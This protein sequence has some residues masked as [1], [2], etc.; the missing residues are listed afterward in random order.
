MSSFFGPGIARSGSV[1][2]MVGSIENYRINNTYISQYQFPLDTPKFFT[3]LSIQTYSRKD[4]LSMN[5]N[6]DTSTRV[7]LP[8]PMHLI[9]N[10]GVR[11][12]ESSFGPFVGMATHVAMQ[13]GGAVY[14]G[15]KGM[16]SGTKTIQDLG[17]DALNNV[18]NAAESGVGLGTAGLVAGADQISG[19]VGQTLRQAAGAIA[20]L[21]PNEFF[22]ILLE[23]PQYKRHQLVWHLVPRNARE[24]HVIKYIIELL[25]NS[26]APGLAL[27][28]AL[29]NFPKIFNIAFLPNYNHLF[30]FKPAVLENMSIDYSPSGQASFYH[31]YGNYEDAAPESYRITCQFTELEYWLHSDFDADAPSPYKTQGEHRNSENVMG[32]TF[33]KEVVSPLMTSTVDT[34]D[35]AIGP[36]QEYFGKW[37]NRNNTPGT[38]E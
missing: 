34:M 31:S 2:S 21:S 32:D 33:M 1:R 26:M 38:S 5:V 24:S 27:G 17:A 12:D 9:D 29:F 14:D 10:H 37:F 25:N 28:G 15:I 23:R 11:Y 19:A 36:L 35:P 6:L 7:I 13:A 22:T 30:K 20:G 16:V 18:P 4:L 3:S 8:M